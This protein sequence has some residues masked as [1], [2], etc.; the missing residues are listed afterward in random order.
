MPTNALRE[1]LI[2]VLDAYV[3]KAFRKPKCKF[4]VHLDGETIHID[5]SCLNINLPNFW[6]GEW[7][8][9]YIIENGS[10]IGN[11]KINCHYYEKGNMQ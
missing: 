2:P 6:T 11:I 4:N 8:S 10:M 5:I 3:K 7:Q 9:S 1:S